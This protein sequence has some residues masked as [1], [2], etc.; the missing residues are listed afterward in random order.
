MGFKEPDLWHRTGPGQP[1]VH[2]NDISGCT[3][4]YEYT[5]GSTAK[6]PLLLKFTIFYLLKIRTGTCSITDP[7]GEGRQEQDRNGRPI[8]VKTESFF[9][10]QFK[11]SLQKF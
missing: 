8:A 2:V 6:W 1:P 10:H 4:H 7:V 5:T 3:V 11:N 9:C